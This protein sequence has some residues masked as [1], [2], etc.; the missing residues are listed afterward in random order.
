MAKVTFITFYN[1]YSVAVSCLSS[2]LMR[3]GHD[4]S[5]IFFK[6]PLSIKIP[7]FSENPAHYEQVEQDG[8]IYGQ[9]IDINKWTTSEVD[10]LINKLNELSPDVICI[11]CRTHEKELVLDVLPKVKEKCDAVMVAGGYGPSIEPEMFSDLVDYVFIGEAEDSIVELIEEIEKGNSLLEFD[12][13]AYKKDGKFYKNKLRKP[14]MAQPRFQVFPDQ[15]FV[16]E[17]DKLFK[18]N[19]GGDFLRREHCYSTTVGRGCVSTCSYC[20]V[21]QWEDMYHREG[22]KLKKRRNRP[23]QNVIDELISI[24]DKKFTFIILRDEFLT[25]PVEYLKEFFE[26]YEKHV[27]LPFWA[28]FVP[29]QMIKHPELLKMA[30]DAGFVATENGI[31]SGSDKINRE[32][33]TRFIPNE[34]VVEYVNLLSKYKINSKV[35]FIIFNPAEDDK[36]NDE[37]IKIIQSLPKELPR[38]RC[39]PVLPRLTF[40]E[41]TPIA[42]ILVDKKILPKDYDHHYATAILYYLCFVMPK[43]E[44]EKIKQQYR[45]GEISR[46]YLLEFYQ[47]YMKENRIEFVP[48]THD[49]PDSITTYRYERILKKNNFDEIIIWGAGSYYKELEYIF[50]DSKVLYHIDDGEEDALINNTVSPEV[51][52][53]KTKSVPIFVCSKFKMEIKMR[54][55]NEFSQHIDE[56]YV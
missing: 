22:F 55:V 18:F 12:N 14:D 20:A 33:F 49:I 40:M 50:K 9:M 47:S 44:F 35:D 3:A 15:A 7:W 39:Y 38:C 51:L 45:S 54:I 53:K 42:K 2:S 52:L 41:F 5:T 24:K 43:D 27:H 10:L 28:Q 31:Q 48:G 19:E 21:S 34:S 46:E 4:V 6:L 37:T 17:Q 56:I 16:I 26:L 11:S 36:D 32:V 30:V 23:V 8:L 29:S 25:G 1:D 13:I